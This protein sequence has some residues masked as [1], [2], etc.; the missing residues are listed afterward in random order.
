M[1]VEGKKYLRRFYFTPRRRDE[2][3]EKHINLPFGLKL[4]YFYIGDEDRQLHNHPWKWAVSYIILGGYL[5][6]RRNDNTFAVETRDVT[7]GSLNFISGECFHRVI[8]KPDAKHVW[9]LFLTG[10]RTKDWGFWNRDT[11]EY[12]SYEDYVTSDEQGYINRTKNK[13]ASQE[14]SQ[15]TGHAAQ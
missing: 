7:P 14:E 2:F 11:Q 1:K 8:K 12:T 13:E 3:G 5:E 15:K 4:H 6:E 10:P 9:T